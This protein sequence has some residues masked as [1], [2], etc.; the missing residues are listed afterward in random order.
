M[1]RIVR[2]N[3]EGRVYKVEFTKGEGAEKGAGIVGL[4]RVL[5]GLMG[6][7]EDPLLG[8][9]VSVLSFMAENNDQP[10]YKNIP[11]RICSYHRS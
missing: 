4:T 1:L 3:E 5:N 9:V 2:W 10:M 8:K 7:S 6:K 11:G